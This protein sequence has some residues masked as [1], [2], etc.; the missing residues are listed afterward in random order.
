MPVALYFTKEL[1]AWIMMDGRP[2]QA[3]AVET[4]QPNSITCWIASEAGKECIAMSQSA[5]V[6]ITDSL[7]V[8]QKFSVNWRNVWRGFPLQGTVIIDGVVCDNH[9]MLDAMNYPDRPNAVGVYYARTSECTRRDFMFSAINVTDDDAYLHTISRTYSFGTIR[10]ELWRLN[11]TNVVT[12]SLEHQLGTQVLESQ[13]VHERSKKAGTHHVR[14]SEEYYS[15]APVVDV[16]TADKM[17]IVPYVTF[18][19]KYRPMAMLMANGI[20]PRPVPAADRA[21]AA[22][23]RTL[24]AKLAALR[25][26]ARQTGAAAPLAHRQVKTEDGVSKSASPSRSSK[27]SPMKR[28]PEIIDLTVD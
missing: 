24:E 8:L 15:P 5:L 16:V 3:Y 27:R 4:Q 26:K 12:E 14:Y 1:S 9:I 18:T 17:D 23:I 2:L 22:E 19:F 10:L 6:L 21:A 11:V 28:P 13:V 20:V 25:E 7:F